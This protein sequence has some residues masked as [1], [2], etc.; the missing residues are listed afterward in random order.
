MLGPRRYIDFHAGLPT[1]PNDTTPCN[2]V[3]N[4]TKK[5]D[6]GFHFKKFN[7]CK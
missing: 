7:E 6:L 5:K 1:T 3:C 4:T 2:G